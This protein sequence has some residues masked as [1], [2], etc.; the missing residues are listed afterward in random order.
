MLKKDEEIRWKTVQDSSNQSIDGSSNVSGPSN[1]RVQPGE[2]P[3]NDIEIEGG[4]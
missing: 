3:A 2:T 4:L 1:V